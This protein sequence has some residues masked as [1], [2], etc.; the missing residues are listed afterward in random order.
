MPFPLRSLTLAVPAIDQVTLFRASEFE[1]HATWCQNILL[2]R[3]TV[4]E[5]QCTQEA[6]DILLMPLPLGHPIPFL[7]GRVVWA[8]C[9]MVVRRLVLAKPARLKG[10]QLSS[11]VSEAKAT[12]VAINLR[13]PAPVSLR[14]QSY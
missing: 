1:A 12:E 3:D 6:S 2:E 4:S 13:C 7:G 10:P 8:A 11:V 14:A 9:S 5:G